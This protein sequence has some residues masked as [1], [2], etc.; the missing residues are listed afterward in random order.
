M[1]GRTQRCVSDHRA[2][3]S[4]W[5]SSIIAS[6]ASPQTSRKGAS[7]PERRRSSAASSAAMRRSRSSTSRSTSLRSTFSGQPSLNSLWG[8]R[9]PVPLRNSDKAAL[10]S[11]MAD[12]MASM[13]AP[14]RRRCK[15]APL[16]SASSMS[17]P[18]SASCASAIAS[19]TRSQ[20]CFSRPLMVGHKRSATS[21]SRSGLPS[22]PT[23]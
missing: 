8:M 14:R 10:A 6:M 7:A 23:S 21:W 11:S 18:V 19:S 12:S 16:A 4:H 20:T 15:P 22:S 9:R 5:S 2:T 1:V 17:A 3:A 13:V